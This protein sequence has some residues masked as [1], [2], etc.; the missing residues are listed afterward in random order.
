MKYDCAI[1]LPFITSLQTLFWNIALKEFLTQRWM[2]ITTHNNLSNVHFDYHLNFPKRRCMT[3]QERCKTISGEMHIF[4]G[5]HS[6][7]PRN[8][9]S[10]WRFEPSLFIH[11]T[12]RDACREVRFGFKQALACEQALKLNWEPASMTNEFEYLPC[13]VRFSK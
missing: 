9:T 13:N 4:P 6:T 1:I 2:A 12:F 10:N 11:L 7:W 5:Q 3:F 8:T